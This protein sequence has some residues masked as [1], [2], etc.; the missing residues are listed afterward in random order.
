MRIAEMTD[1]QFSF[2][3]HRPVPNGFL[4]DQPFARKSTHFAT[5]PS[6]PA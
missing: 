5:L 4:P 3:P 1:A 2:C 6:Y